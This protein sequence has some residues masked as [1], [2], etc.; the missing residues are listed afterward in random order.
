MGCASL[1]QF[2]LATSFLL[3][4]K[5]INV[6]LSIN[7]DMHMLPKMSP[8]AS[9]TRQTTATVRPS[10]YFCRKIPSSMHQYMVEEMFWEE[11]AN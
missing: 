9:S 5:L 8:M 6:S 2:R 7:Y 4:K 3:T 10:A 11:S 1:L